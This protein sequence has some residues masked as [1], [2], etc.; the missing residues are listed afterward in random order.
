MR[1]M[2][3]RRIA[4]AEGWA[5]ASDGVQGILQ[6]RRADGWRPVCFVRSS[7]DVL[8]RCMRENGVPANVACHLVAGLPSTFDEWADTPK[9]AACGPFGASDID[10]NGGPATTPA[11]TPAPA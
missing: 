10:L 9:T 5:L 4:R 7:R 3:D 8:V 11:T 6:K 1:G 2:K